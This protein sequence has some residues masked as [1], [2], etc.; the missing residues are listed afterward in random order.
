MNKIVLFSMFAWG[1]PLADMAAQGMIVNEFSNGTSGVGG[2]S[3]EYI[4]FIVVGSAVDPTGNV[5]LS[6]FIIDDNNGDFEGGSSTGVAQG[7]FRIVPGCYTS[8]PVGSIIVIYNAN[9]RDA[10]IPPD[11]PTDANGDGVYIIPHTNACIQVCSTLPNTSNPAYTPCTYV[12]TTLTGVT[13]WQAGGAGAIGFANSG[14]APQV[15]RPDGSFY[16]GFSY[17][18][19]DAPFPSFPAVFGGGNSFNAG[20]GVGTSSAYIFNC[21]NWTTSTNFA[22]ITSA[23]ITPGAANTANN[24]IIIENIQNGDLNYDD[25]S[26]ADNCVLLAI[27]LLR[28]GGKAQEGRVLL[29]WEVATSST[30][31]RFEV[32]RSHNGIGFETITEVAANAESVLYSAVDALPLPLGYYRLKCY[33][34]DGTIKFSNII[35]FEILK[36]QNQEWLVYPNPA[37]QTLNIEFAEATAETMDFEV[38]DA[39]GRVAAKGQWQSGLQLYSLDVEAL[40]AGYY[41]LYIKTPNNSYRQRWIKG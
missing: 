4:E 32:Q 25:L 2:G 39:L 24:A 23:A 15:R 17:G 30:A 35:A 19:V 20:T 1:L 38:M 33:D 29:D 36:N 3:Q 12:A 9:D 7:H 16:H 8:V 37:R 41:V 18:N 22:K 40:T 14:D 10:L 28:W 34:A 27:D 26:D 6:G 13:S 21:G 5:N 11:D 31:A